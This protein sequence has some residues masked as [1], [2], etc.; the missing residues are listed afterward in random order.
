MTFHNYFIDLCYA[1]ARKSKDT[2]VKVGAII[3]GRENQIVSTGYNGF[4][5]RIKE[6]FSRQERPAKYLWTEHAERNAIYQAAMNGV[7][8][9]R[10]LIYTPW[11]PCADCA[12]AI[13]QSG[14][15]TVVTDGNA[16]E[17]TSSGDAER[18]EKWKESQKVTSIMFEEAGI[19]HIIY[20]S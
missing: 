9:N 2:S 19:E 6:K 10:C 14:I 12:R 18:D 5:R 8:V 13:I 11:L 1:I 4:P 16:V 7:S 3:V 17:F 15:K 20:H